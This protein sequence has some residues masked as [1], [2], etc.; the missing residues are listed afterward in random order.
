MGEA[1][2]IDRTPGRMV[3]CSLACL[4]LAFICFMV[5]GVMVETN[6]AEGLGALLLG[7]AWLFGLGWLPLL[8][9]AIIVRLSSR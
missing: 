3:V 8:F 4:Y 9:L 7:F 6:A 5:G 2:T 1:K